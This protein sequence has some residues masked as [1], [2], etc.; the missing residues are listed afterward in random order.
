MTNR[1][2]R[3][4]LLFEFSALSKKEEVDVEESE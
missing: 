3:N 4:V 1:E 2:Q